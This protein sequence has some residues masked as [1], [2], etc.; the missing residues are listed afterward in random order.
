M[1]R[2][3]YSIPCRFL[4]DNDTESVVKWVEA[5]PDALTLDRANIITSQDW[6]LDRGLL[7]VEVGEQEGR[8]IFKIAHA[9][10]GLGR[11][12]V[13]GTDAD[14]DEGG[15]YEPELPP[16]AYSADGYPLCCD[17]PRRIRGGA[18]GSGRTAVSIFRRMNY[19]GAGASGR[20]AVTVYPAIHVY[21]GAAASGRAGAVVIPWSDPAHGGMMI[22]GAVPDIYTPGT[23]E[24]G[25]DCASAGVGD[26]GTPYTHDLPLPGAE[27]WWK[28]LAPTTGQYHLSSTDLGTSGHVVSFKLTTDCLDVIDI[29]TSL[30]G[31]PCWQFSAPAGSFICV[32]ITSS[33]GS[34]TYTFQVDPGAC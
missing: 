1:M 14:F 17:P 25:A 19:G 18:G 33:G 20:A 16:V 28:F 5:R 23:P 13:C 3:P 32:V 10:V 8:R 26:F 27:Q 22:G 2:R 11:G 30:D 15:L 12:H 34:G 9:P 29:P 24:P 7:P 31:P 4:R 6:E 21:G